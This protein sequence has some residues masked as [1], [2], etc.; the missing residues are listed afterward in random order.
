MTLAHAWAIALVGLDGHVVEVA[1]DIAAGLPKTTL[2][3]LPDASLSEARDRVRAAVTNSGETFPNR[4]LTIGLSPAT[5]PKAGSH[6]DLAIASSLLA[7]TGALPAA[8][9]R[10]VV[11]IGE[12]GLDGRV[13]EVRGTLAM[14][15]AA[16]NAGFGQVI[17]PELNAGEAKLVP[18]IAVIG[19]RSLRQVLAIARGLP[20]PDEDRPSPEPRLISDS[21]GRAAADADLADVI[22]QQ[23]GRH[24]MEIAAAGGHHVFLHGPPGAGK[25][26]LAERLPGLLPDLSTFEAL[27]VSA[28]HSLAGLLSTE[29]ELVTRPPFV[30]PHHSASLASLVGGGSG[31]PRPGAISCAHHGVLFIDEVPEMHPSKLDALRQPIESGVVEVHRA[32]AVAKYPAR[33]VLTMAANPC[34]CGHFETPGAICSCTTQGVRRYQQRISGPIKDRIDIQRQILPTSRFAMNSD[35]GGIE[36]TATV[37]ARVTEARDRQVFRYIGRD[38]Q[39]NSDLPGSAL[40]REFRPAEGSTKI[41]EEQYRAGHLTA[42][43]VDRVLRLAWTLADLEGADR[44]I[45]DHVQRAYQLRTGMPVVDTPT[46]IRIVP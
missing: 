2:I 9:L 34:P 35:L 42:R 27:E 1:A 31:L 11:L 14:T 18:D 16:A 20:L 29:A 45:A 30:A 46:P 10:K 25:T 3:G 32:V 17:V 23:D 36:T 21:L 33:F 7:A 13:R 43:G 12:L 44:P 38:W 26:M 28:I 22:G 40:R 39:L 4:K 41:L 5:L 37:A 6:Y 8:A 19:V 15:L 24:A